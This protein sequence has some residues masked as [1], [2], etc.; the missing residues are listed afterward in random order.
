[1]LGLTIIRTARLDYLLATE[2]H[3]DGTVERLKNQ[4]NNLRDAN[5]DANAAKVL[6]E[7]KLTQ[8]LADLSA[9]TQELA[10]WRANGQL[11]D[12]K[13]GRLIPKAKVEL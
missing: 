9:A 3:F 4:V 11:R 13:T 1:M 12:P 7:S 6:L 2:K 8:A 5:R 10:K